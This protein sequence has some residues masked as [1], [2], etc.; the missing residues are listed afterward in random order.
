MRMA[1][2]SDCASGCTENSAGGLLRNTDAH[3]EATRRIDA[4]SART[5]VPDEYMSFTIFLYLAS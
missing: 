1:S 4:A 5:A 2:P 3:T